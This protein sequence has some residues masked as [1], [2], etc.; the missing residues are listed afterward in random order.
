MSMTFGSRHVARRIVALAVGA[1]ALTG[2]SLAAQDPGTSALE[3]LP[4]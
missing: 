1:I 2:G 3:W 4:R